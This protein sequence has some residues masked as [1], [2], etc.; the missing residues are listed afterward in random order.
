MFVLL[1]THH[2]TFHFNLQVSQI[3][4]SDSGSI[5]SMAA[6]NI[7]DSLTKKMSKSDAEYLLDKLIRDKWIGKVTSFW[8]FFF[9]S[10]LFLKKRKGNVDGNVELCCN[11]PVEGQSLESN[12]IKN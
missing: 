3:V 8:L 6:V 12:Q 5:G 4:Q 7:V 11:V 10:A 9:K 1:L 2:K